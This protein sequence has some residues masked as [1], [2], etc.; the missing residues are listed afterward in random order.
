LV[1]YAGYPV[2]GENIIPNGQQP[3]PVFYANDTGQAEGAPSTVTF[4]IPNVPNGVYTVDLVP[5]IYTPPVPA[6]PEGCS[7]PYPCRSILFAA[8]GG[9]PIF[10]VG[11]PA[12]GLGAAVNT[13]FSSAVALGFE[14]TGNVSI[15]RAQAT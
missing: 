4:T 7:I 2:G 10:T 3:I 13:V 5:G 6:N 8:D 12:T 9:A 15:T 11:P 14:E 1:W